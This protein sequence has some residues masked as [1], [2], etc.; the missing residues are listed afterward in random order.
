MHRGY[1]PIWRKFFDH[2]LWAEDRKFSKAEAWIDI[3]ANTNFKDDPIQRL[4][5]GRMVAIEYGHCLMTT[6]YCGTRWK[7]HKNSV[8]KFFDLLVKMEQIELKNA[9]QMTLIKVINFEIYDPKRI[10]DVPS[11]EPSEWPV[12]GQCVAKLNT[13]KN[14]K[15]LKTSVSSLSGTCHQVQ[16]DDRISNSKSPPPCPHQKIIES[17]HKNLPALPE[18]QVW[19]STSRKNLTSRW[20]EDTQ[21]QL[22]EYWD[23]FFEYVGRSDFLMGRKTDFRA[24][25]HWL[26]KPTN[27]AKVVN[28][29][30]HHK[31]TFQTKLQS[32]GERWLQK[33]MMKEAT[34]NDTC[35]P[36]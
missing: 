36:S 26:V 14:Y 18:I 7:W 33:Q 3:L 16:P 23:Q 25:L 10:S 30:Y 22:V 27:F 9:Q 6:R 17:Y 24:D 29:R 19:D 35:Q 34:M 28:G 32:V 20:R 1:V 4:V 31:N 13:L 8:K 12:S 21:R 15:T 5:R 11:D 2:P